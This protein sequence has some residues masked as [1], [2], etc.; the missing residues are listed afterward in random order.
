MVMSNEINKST[1]V[2]LHRYAGAKGKYTS[3]NKKKNELIKIKSLMTGE[4]VRLSHGHYCLEASQVSTEASVLS[5]N[6]SESLNAAYGVFF[7]ENE[8]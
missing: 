4:A 1:I 5:L 7:Y 8:E 6:A 3:A 2:H